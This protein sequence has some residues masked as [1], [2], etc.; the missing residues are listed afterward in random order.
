[1]SWCGGWALAIP[2]ASPRK[3][4]A[5]EFIRFMTSDRASFICMESDRQLAEAMGRL[6]LPP[7]YPVPSLNEYAF[8]KYVL[9]NP[10]VPR[11]FVHAQR[12][13]NDLLPVS[14]YRPITP[15]GQLLWNEHISAMEAALYHRMTPQQALNRLLAVVQR[16][17]DRALSPPAGRPINSWGPFYLGYAALLLVVAVLLYLWDT[18]AGFRKRLAARLHFRRPGDS[19]I[20]GSSGGFYRRQWGGG[21]GF[22]A[23]LR[24]SG[25]CHG[26]SPVALAG[27]AVVGDGLG[28]SAQ[29]R[30]HGPLRYLPAMGRGSV[31]DVRERGERPPPPA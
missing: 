9:G 22:R 19:V 17:L 10:D 4:A 29:R 1:M 23:G 2:T 14:R 25:T 8:T 28:K 26:R 16:R 27:C 13:L 11:K 21:I 31:S 12:L 30:R 6:Y 7:Q 15:V 24:T 3:A 20:E 18:K 5:W